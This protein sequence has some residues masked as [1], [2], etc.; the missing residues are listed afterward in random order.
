MEYNIFP[1]QGIGSIKFGM[2]NIDV[3]N[4][5]SKEPDS[6]SLVN[7]SWDA[8]ARH[9]EIFNEKDLIAL[10]DENYHLVKILIYTSLDM[11][12]IP[13]LNGQPILDVMF[14]V[15]E[16]HILS[17]DNK[18]IL[19]NQGAFS[20]RLGVSITGCN[21]YQAVEKVEI[22]RPGYFSQYKS[23][24]KSDSIEYLTGNTQL[25]SSHFDSPY[26]YVVTLYGESVG[27][28]LWSYEEAIESTYVE[29][30][31]G[32]SIREGEWEREGLIEFKRIYDAE[33]DSDEY[34][35]EMQVARITRWQNPRI[36]S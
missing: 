29:V 14:Y 17:L 10:Y 11:S 15:A 7:R 9:R 32:G 16:K 1:N 4:V 33:Y 13:L 22:C 35:F 3:R 23:Y 30:D 19:T 34:D 26:Y 27:K 2:K 24:F 28:V 18:L 25:K 8:I 36:W 20:E 5:L 6:I 21:R 31:E 12:S